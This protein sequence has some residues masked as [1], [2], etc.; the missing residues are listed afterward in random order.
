MLSE[1]KHLDCPLR[2]NSVKDLNWRLRINSAK[3]LVYPV[4]RIEILHFV[5]DDKRRA[6]HDR[7]RG[8]HDKPVSG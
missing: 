8:Q 4:L 5:Q 2:V 3:N 7:R 6:Q 1:A